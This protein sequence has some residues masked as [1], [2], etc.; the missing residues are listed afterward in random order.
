MFY[1]LMCFLVSAAHRFI[2]HCF[3]SSVFFTGLMLL[4][5][6]AHAETTFSDLRI[7]API[8]GQSVSAGYFVMKSSDGQARQLVAVSSPDAERVEMHTHTHHD[9]MMHMVKLDKIDLPSD[10]EVVFEPGGHHLMVFSPS[11][12]A[13]VN[14]SMSFSF[15]FE[16]GER[17]DVEAGV[18][19]WSRPHSDHKSEKKSEKKSGHHH[20]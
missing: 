19:E 16:S 17:V 4:S 1:P 20:H 14:G 15:E 2:R 10:T 7:K 6:S 9:G 5:V 12:E 13:I 18:E 11:E 8:P 3:F